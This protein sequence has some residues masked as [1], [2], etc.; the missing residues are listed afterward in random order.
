MLFDIC[1]WYAICFI[2]CVFHEFGH[3]TMARLFEWK[4]SNFQIRWYCEGNVN[5]VVPITHRYSCKYF[6]VCIIGPVVGLFTTLICFYFISLPHYMRFFCISS[7]LLTFFIG[8]DSQICLCII[9]SKTN[10]V[11]ET[12][13][14]VRNFMDKLQWHI[15]LIICIWTFI[16]FLL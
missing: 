12:I 15:Y 3:Y 7:D 5:I 13:S 10:I 6:L 1:L 16:L 14:R 9:L 2:S 11:S 4:V 8:S